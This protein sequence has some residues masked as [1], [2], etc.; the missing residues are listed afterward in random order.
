V[1]QLTLTSDGIW[2]VPATSAAAEES[3]TPANDSPR[4]FPDGSRLYH[5]RLNVY[6]SAGLIHA[7]QAARGLLVDMYV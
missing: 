6:T 5:S 2:E 3:A 1:V 7:R 4:R